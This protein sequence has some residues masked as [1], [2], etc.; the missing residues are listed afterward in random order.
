MAPSPGYAP[1]VRWYWSVSIQKVVKFPFQLTV[2]A[3]LITERNNIFIFVESSSI[4]SSA[5]KILDVC[6]NAELPCQ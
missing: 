6:Q 2:Y 5:S 1:G 4:T 3:P